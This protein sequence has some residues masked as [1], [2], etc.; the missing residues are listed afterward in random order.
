MMLCSSGTAFVVSH[1]QALCEVMLWW[2]TQ[3]SAIWW[4]TGMMFVDKFS[5]TLLESAQAVQLRSFWTALL[6]VGNTLAWAFLFV[7]WMPLLFVLAGFKH[8]HFCTAALW[9][10]ELE[11]TCTVWRGAH[12]VTTDKKRR[13]KIWLRKSVTGRFIDA[14]KSLPGQGSLYC[15]QVSYIFLCC[16]SSCGASSVLKCRGAGKAS[17]IS[18]DLQGCWVRVRVEMCWPAPSFPLIFGDLL[19][20]RGRE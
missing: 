9:P 8:W 1:L 16:G 12:W 4:E 6:A 2:K 15:C 5:L 7:V 3:N 11:N 13:M 14:D 20:S 19:Y 18:W 10:L 17:R